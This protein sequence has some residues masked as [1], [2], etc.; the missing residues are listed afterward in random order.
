MPYV[1][2]DVNNYFPSYDGFKQSKVSF[3]LLNSN[4]KILNIN[5]KETNELI[6]KEDEDKVF[7][8]YEFNQI[9]YEFSIMIRPF[10]WKIENNNNL[11]FLPNTK[12]Y[13]SLNDLT[14]FGD[15]ILTFRNNTDEKFY[16][17]INNNK[18]DSKYI[19]IY[20]NTKRII[21]LK[22]YFEFIANS[23]KEALIYIEQD[24]KKI[25]DICSFR[26]NLAITNLN[27]FSSDDYEIIL[28]EED[29]L[30][31]NRELRCRYID[32]PYEYFVIPI[33]NGQTMMSID[34]N[35][36][37]FCSNFIAEIALK[38]DKNIFNVEENEK[39]EILDSSNSVIVN[40]YDNKK[41]YVNFNI[42]NENEFNNCLYSYL[43]YRFNKK[44]ISDDVLYKKIII[45]LLYKLISARIIYGDEIIIQN[46]LKYNIDKNK[47]EIILN[48]LRMY[49]P[50]LTNHQFSSSEYKQIERFNP[51]IYVVYS[52]I[53]C[54]YNQIDKLLLDNCSY[55]DRFKDKE[56]FMFAHKYEL[57]KDIDDI[58]NFK[59]YI[60]N[61]KAIFNNKKEEELYLM[62]LID[63]LIKK[64]NKFSLND[65]KL[66]DKLSGYIKN[67]YNKYPNKLVNEI[68]V[69]TS[70]RK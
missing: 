66:I 2:K 22:E 43:T 63:F 53:K 13:L 69:Q 12:G 45:Q 16:I 57:F 60:K 40:L 37:Q 56:L 18:E 5:L 62:V 34:K 52:L 58:E 8:I 6:C 70:R 67:I 68:F 14:K 24:Y 38:K 65:I 21:S 32:K 51:Y 3:K 42:E 54:D 4:I 44:L 10:S 29:G 19:K 50:I 35:D 46:L 59:L 9:R 39:I 1:E 27:I 41:P 20:P 15:C 17:K 48:D 55:F 25:C 23:E 49:M 33:P 30:K 47:F 26:M 61:A 11:M 7:G 31:I 28:W 36:D 64:G